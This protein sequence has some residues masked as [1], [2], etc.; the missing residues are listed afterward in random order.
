MRQSLL[1]WALPFMACGALASKPL[2]EY[3]CGDS[4][5]GSGWINDDTLTY[6][7]TIVNVTG[8]FTVHLQMLDFHPSSPSCNPEVDCSFVG[9]GKV[10]ANRST[11]GPNSQT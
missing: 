4:G 5:T 6:W 9:N 3:T 2:P 8:P 1:W 10:R 11:T 7:G